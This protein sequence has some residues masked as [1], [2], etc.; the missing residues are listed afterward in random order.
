MEP[1]SGFAEQPGPVKAESEEQEPAQWQ[2]LPVLSEQQSGAV[3]LILAY[4]APVLDKRQTSRLLREVSAVYPLPAQPH[5]KRVRPSR[6][7]GGA[8]S[9]DLLLC[10]AGPS[11]GPRSL[12]G[13]AAPAGRKLAIAR[14]AASAIPSAGVSL[15]P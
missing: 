12:A 10:L 5:L 9:S 14:R 11:A 1:T 6:S 15:A 7:A 4:A 8:Q 13:S 3:E 2:A